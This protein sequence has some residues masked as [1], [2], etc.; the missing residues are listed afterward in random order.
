MTRLRLLL[1][2]VLLAGC[3]GGPAAPAQDADAPRWAHVRVTD[4]DGTLLYSSWPGEGGVLA[5][6]SIPEGPL[7]WP[8]E[9]A[10]SRLSLWTPFLDA[11]QRAPPNATLRFEGH[12]VP[13]L[14]QERLEIA[15]HLDVPRYE[16]LRRAQ[17]DENLA[18]ATAGARMHYLG[19]IPLDVL[20]ADEE[21]LVLRYAIDAPLRL[22]LPRAVGLELAAEPLPGGIVRFR[23]EAPEGAFTA[24]ANCQAPRQLLASGYYLVREEREDAFV[25]DRYVGAA[26]PALV[27]RT[28]DLEV[29]FFDGA[30]PEGAPPSLPASIP[31]HH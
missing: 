29:T 17:V 28:V 5:D 23:L 19:L 26:E 7:W 3:L 12:V 25:V 9:A 8:R 6:P 31:H 27:G 16:I 1:P 4:A 20:A 11:L 10:S 22:P 2:L 14:R 21:L 18:N 15:R 30:P 24:H 13:E